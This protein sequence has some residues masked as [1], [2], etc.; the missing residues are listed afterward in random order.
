M[1]LGTPTPQSPWIEQVHPRPDC[2]LVAGNKVNNHPLGPLS[3]PTRWRQLPARVGSPWERKKEAGRSASS[4]PSARG[5]NSRFCPGRRSLLCPQ[6]V[7]F[8]G[9]GFRTE[10]ESLLAWVATAWKELGKKGP[11][12]AAPC[13]REEAEPWGQRV[14][15]HRAPVCTLMHSRARP[16]SLGRSGP[17]LS[18]PRAFRDVAFHCPSGVHPFR[19]PCWFGLGPCLSRVT[20]DRPWPQGK[21]CW[22]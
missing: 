20:Q 8:M 6:W 3:G 14:S 7:R 22:I 16:C 21:S 4:G 15:G 9:C 17:L 18:V 1:L 5:G 10:K 12:R 11:P 19:F 13:R 2:E